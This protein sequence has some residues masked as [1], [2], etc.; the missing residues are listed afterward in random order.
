M[1]S[2]NIKFQTLRKRRV[3]LKIK[4]S[5]NIIIKLKIVIVALGL[6][7]RRAKMTRLEK[8]V[9]CRNHLSFR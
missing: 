3:P 1:F 5:N 4:S 6:G 9:G 7:C 8:F 2:A